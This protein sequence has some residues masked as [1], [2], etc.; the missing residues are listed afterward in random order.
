VK[1]TGFATEIKSNPPKVL[2]ATKC[3]AF[4]KLSDLKYSLYVLCMKILDTIF[5]DKIPARWLDLS[6]LTTL[7]PFLR[8]QC[9]D[10]FYLFAVFSKARS[11]VHLPGRQR[12]GQ[13]SAGP[14]LLR[15][16]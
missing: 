2:I 5:F 6:S 8:Q 10:N 16:I 12:N 13:V 14:I 7:K 11:A 9:A 15:F 1:T 3:C 4:V